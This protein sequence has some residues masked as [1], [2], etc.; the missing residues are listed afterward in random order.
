[1]RKKKELSIKLTSTN[2]SH[3]KTHTQLM[4]CLNKYRLTKAYSF[5]VQI[6]FCSSNEKSSYMLEHCMSKRCSAT[7][8]K[9]VMSNNIQCILFFVN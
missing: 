1:M 3:E 8:L 4:C 7:T 6:E 9:L 5:F 2:I